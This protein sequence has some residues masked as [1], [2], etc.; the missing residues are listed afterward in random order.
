MTVPTISR[1]RLSNEKT[2]QLNK[3]TALMLIKDNLK[4][5]RDR[6][7]PTPKSSGI[8]KFKHLKPPPNS[9]NICHAWRFPLASG[10]PLLHAS[11]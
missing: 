11:A 4:E 10:S 9:L 7:L 2:S 6:K 1:D 3:N 5:D 8:H